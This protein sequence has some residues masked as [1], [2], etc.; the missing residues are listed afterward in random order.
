ST[1]GEIDHVQH[2][3]DDGQAEAQQRIERAVDEPQKKLTEE[4]LRRDAE[5]LEHLKCS[6][7]LA[8]STVKGD[9]GCEWRDKASQWA[10]LPA[11]GSGG[12]VHPPCLTIRQ[13][14]HSCAP[15]A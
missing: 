10:S 12:K 14:P 6:S 1:V 7:A 9:R 8:P 13:P 15:Q 11:I 3:E 2:A 5:Q 4:S